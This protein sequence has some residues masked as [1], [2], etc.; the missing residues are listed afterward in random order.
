VCVFKAL[1][2]LA[3]AFFGNCLFVT[4]GFLLACDYIGF[5]FGGYAVITAVHCVI[6]V[7]GYLFEAVK[8]AIV[9]FEVALIVRLSVG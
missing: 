2:W 3:L 9:V 6:A 8:V 1:S 7:N 4:Y 5:A